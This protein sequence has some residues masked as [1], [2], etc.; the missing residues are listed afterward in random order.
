LDTDVTGFVGTPDAS[1]AIEH[2]RKPGVSMGRLHAKR[3]FIATSG[4]Y[5][6]AF[7]PDFVN[8]H[9]YDP[10]TGYSPQELASVTVIAD[11]GAK[12]DALATAFM[13]MGS[14]KAETLVQ[15][16][17]TIGAVLIGKDLGIK[18]LLKGDQSFFPTA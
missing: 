4:D 1:F 5:G 8:N 6:Y 12:A 3:G 18:I 2:P 11:S 16:D 17:A 13:V 7:S 9:I 10:R 15:Q 14:A